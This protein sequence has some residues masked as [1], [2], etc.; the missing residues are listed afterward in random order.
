MWRRIVIFLFAALVAGVDRNK[1]K[2]CSQSGFCQRCRGLKGGETPFV[3][4]PATLHLSPT[5]V[6][7]L[8][9]NTHNGVKFKLELFGLLDNTF[10]N[11]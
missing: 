7:S 1:F 4:D 2:T 3:L 5:A 8:L 6:E 9:V 10:R 11:H